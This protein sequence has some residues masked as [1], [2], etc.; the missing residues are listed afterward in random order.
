MTQSTLFY[1]SLTS[2]NSDQIIERLGYLAELE[3]ADQADRD[4]E[5][6][7]DDEWFYQESPPLDLMELQWEAQ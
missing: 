2:P 7:S 6:L 4:A 1:Q 5:T 3:L